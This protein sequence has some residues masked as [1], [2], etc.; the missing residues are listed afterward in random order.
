MTNP[1]QPNFRPERALPPN[2]GPAPSGG[3]DKTIT[4]VVGV[5]AIVLILVV[6]GYFVA[7]KGGEAVGKGIVREA[8]GSGASVDSGGAAKPSGDFSKVDP[9]TLTVDQFYD[10]S[11]YPEAY[12]IRWADKIVDERTKNAIPAINSLLALDK[13]DPLTPYAQPSLENTGQ[14][15]VTQ[16]TIVEY[17]A[18]VATTPDEGRKILAAAYQADNPGLDKTMGQI[19][20]GQ[21]PIAATFEIWTNNNNVSMESPVFRNKVIANYTPNGNPSKIMVT[22]N[23][24]TQGKSERIVQFKEGRWVTV[25]SIGT[26]DPD[27]VAE[28]ERISSN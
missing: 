24:F 23:K 20:G 11:V 1:Q 7:V 3:K 25:K 21:K 17:I 12:R 9:N 16:Q 13:A 18:S 19:G 28:P 14:E 6:G 26:G 2:P 27:W 15:I 10:D 8:T 22:N 4:I 5:V